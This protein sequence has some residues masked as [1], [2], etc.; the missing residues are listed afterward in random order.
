MSDPMR[1]SLATVLAVSMLTALSA[2][3][4][5][6]QSEDTVGAAAG[7]G[8][9]ATVDGRSAVGANASVA[10]RAGKLVATNRSGRLPSTIIRPLWSLLK[11]IPAVF[12]D[13]QITWA[14]IAGKPAGFADDVDQGSFVSVVT[15]DIAIGAA[16]PDGTTFPSLFNVNRN[17]EVEFFLIPS[18]VAVQLTIDHVVMTRNADGTLNHI[19][20]V[21]NLTALPATFRLRYRVASE[22][23]APASTKRQVKAA[24]FKV[25]K[26]APWK[27]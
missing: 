1:R 17:I 14:E 25:L 21:R 22:G 12:A 9:A 23:I 16:G 8:N 10:G 6:G 24:T 2:S 18:T 5:L 19:V 15:G 7:T 13:G 3:P 11:E 20:Q 27:R 4:V 26:K